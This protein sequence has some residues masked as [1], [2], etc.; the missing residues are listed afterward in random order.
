MTT[1]NQQSFRRLSDRG[2]TVRYTVRCRLDV[3]VVLRYRDSSVVLANEM[4][5]VYRTKITI[6]LISCD[7]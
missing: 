2:Y 5:R 7:G 4:N 1:T 3:T 6:L